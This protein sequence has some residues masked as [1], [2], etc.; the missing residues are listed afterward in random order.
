MK[1]PHSLHEFE[2]S[3]FVIADYY[4]AISSVTKFRNDIYIIFVDAVTC[5]TLCYCHD[6]SCLQLYERKNETPFVLSVVL[7]NYFQRSEIRNIPV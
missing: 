5:T 6:I 1:L 2:Q 4:C 7:V 3:P